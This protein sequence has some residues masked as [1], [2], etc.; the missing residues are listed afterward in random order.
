MFINAL[1]KKWFS[2]T[3]FE[4]CQVCGIRYEKEPGFFYGAMYVSYAFSVM[5]MTMCGVIL[6][7]FFKPDLWVYLVTVAGVVIVLWPVMYRYSR[8]IFL[9]FFGGIRFNPNYS[10]SE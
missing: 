6:N 2:F 1:R 10:S 4:K 5:L 8:S 7:M 3:M 9:H